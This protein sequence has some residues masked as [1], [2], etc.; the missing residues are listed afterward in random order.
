MS[1]NDPFSVAK[2]GPALLPT[3]VAAATMLRFVLVGFWVI[4]WWY[5][6]GFEG[7]HRTEIFFGQQ[8]LP[9]WLAW[10][11]ISFEVVVALCLA[12]G[13]YVPIVC[14]FSLPILISSMI[15]FRRNGFYFPTGGIEFPFLWALV[16]VVQALLGPG[17]LR[18]T[19]PKWLPSVP[20]A[21]FLGP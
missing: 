21:R 17:A 19:P 1:L 4:H 6:V 18:V 15:I 7:M 5:K 16:Q 10:F 3:S 2:P 20:G 13:V 11:D 14:I 9:G 8:G 12:L